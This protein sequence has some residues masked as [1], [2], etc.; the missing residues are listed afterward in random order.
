M[1]LLVYNLLLLVLAPVWVPWM[2]VRTR[3]RKEPPRWGERL[4]WVRIPPPKD[5]RVWLHAV[6]VGEVVAAAPILRELR[7]AAPGLEI[8]LSVTTSSGHRTA[9]EQLDGLFDHL[10]YFPIDLL[11]C[12]WIAMRRVR[13]SV[14]AVMETE[15]WMNFLWTA[16]RFGAK[17]LLL[18]GRISDRNLRRSRPLRRFYAALLR[19]V[20]RPL[21]QSE[22]DAARIELLGARN[23]ETFGNT[24]FDL[25][26]ESP[27]PWR[28]TLGIPEDA[29]VIVV[30]STRGEEEE[31]FVLSALEALDR[32]RL[33]IL[34]A[35]RHLERVPEL[36][37]QVEARFDS[38]G[39]L[40]QHDRARYLLI[41]TYGQLG[42]IYGAADVAVVGGGFANLGGQ[43]L[44]QPLALGVP[45]LHGPHMQNF[46][47]AAESALAVGA[48][49][50][51]ETPESLE[52]NLRELLA[53]PELRAKMGTAGREL[54]RQSA[55][56][57]GRYA[58]AVLAA[59][60][61]KASLH[62]AT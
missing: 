16:R 22:P 42:E 45:V 30:G 43:N 10:F 19:L 29:S 44:I 33:W 17:T 21:M 3:A 23:P 62:I 46:R 13:P 55:G 1:S 39:R 37:A 36:L 5:R 11:P 20:D 32:D 48:S 57:A 26:L 34:H 14:V 58:E 51:C 12:Q 52:S 4:G 28:E 50:V 15:L 53:R 7:K 27:A 18:N 56:A 35:P 47:S 38:T 6:S 24:K 31:A 61:S 8:A 40:S 25:A 2:L 49:R 54:V 59:A 41:D 60:E 9:R